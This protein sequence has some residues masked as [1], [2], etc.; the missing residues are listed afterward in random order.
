MKHYRKQI[1]HILTALLAS[2]ALTVPAGAVNIIADGWAYEGI[3]AEKDGAA[4]VSVR[5]FA[6]TMDNA[7]VTWDDAER[8]VTVV[9]DKLYMTLW[10]N[11]S[12]II[13]NDRYLWCPAGT[14]T[15]NGIMMV[16]LT[17]VSRAFGFSHSWSRTD[18]TAYLKRQT[19]AIDSGEQTY[20]EEDVLWLARIIHAEAQGEPF[21]GKVAVGEVVLNRVK[22][23]EFPDDIYSVIFDSEHGTQFTPTK[24]GTIYNE[25]GEDSVIAAK[26]C[27]DGAKVHGNLLY[28]LN[29]VKAVSAW[30][31]K[32]RPY[33]LTIGEHDFYA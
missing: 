25:P 27:L 2:I 22:S 16:P 4:Y 3:V 31:P 18:N 30:V 26:L 8:K 17:A 10:E 32:N 5:E 6:S 7:V 20:D 1:K 21:L 13:A 12:Y 11:G 19:G 15:E 33:R 28:F 23:E 24:N 29:P 9:T 14:Y